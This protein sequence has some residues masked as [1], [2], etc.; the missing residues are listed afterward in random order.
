MLHRDYYMTRSDGV[1]LYRTYSDERLLIRQ[2]ETG[3][4]YD[5]AVDVESSL[6]TYEETNIKIDKYEES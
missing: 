2:I 3:E 5:E 4:V 6:Y 1:R